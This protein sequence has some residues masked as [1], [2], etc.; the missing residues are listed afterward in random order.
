MYLVYN[1][2]FLI[3]SKKKKID[4]LLTDFENK[5]KFFS[6]LFCKVLCSFEPKTYQL[7]S[8]C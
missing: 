8:I 7:D 5:F 2:Y 4:F 3:Y 1:Y 6:Q